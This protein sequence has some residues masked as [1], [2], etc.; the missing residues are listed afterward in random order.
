MKVSSSFSKRRY[1][2]I[3]VFKFNYNGRLTSNRGKGG[4]YVGV[5]SLEMIE[6]VEELGRDASSTSSCS[7]RERKSA[8]VSLRKS[9]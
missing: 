2:F 6:E 7:R 1:D 9:E 5:I 8:S 4:S 3:A